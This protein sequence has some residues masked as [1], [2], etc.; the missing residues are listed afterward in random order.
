LTITQPQ[1]LVNKYLSQA[2]PALNVNS[3]S[4]G[5][6]TDAKLRDTVFKVPLLNNLKTANLGPIG[7][8]GLGQGGNEQNN[9]APVP[10]PATM[11][12]LGAGLIGLAGSRKMM[13]R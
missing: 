13:K 3:T 5:S 10:E 8:Y 6:D 7:S 4:L 11:L 2:W 1:D 9:P 12:L